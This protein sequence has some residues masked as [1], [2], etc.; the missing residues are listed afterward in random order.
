MPGGSAMYCSGENTISPSFFSRESWVCELRSSDMFFSITL[1]CFILIH[2]MLLQTLRFVKAHQ[3]PPSHPPRKKTGGASSPFSGGKN[4]GAGFRF[5]R[6]GTG[7]D[8]KGRRWGSPVFIPSIWSICD[9]HE[10]RKLP[11]QREFSPGAKH[12]QWKPLTHKAPS[13]ADSACFTPNQTTHKLCVS[14]LCLYVPALCVCSF[15]FASA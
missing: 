12:M 5:Q 8:G 6:A 11:P 15:V 14:P 7:S 10:H 3:H 2:N 13:R 9:S 4:H 1:F